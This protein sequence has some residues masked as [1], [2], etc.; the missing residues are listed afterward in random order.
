MNS[1]AVFLFVSVVISAVGAAFFVYG[2]KQGRVPQLIVGIAMMLYPYFITNIW[3]M[4]GIGAGLTGLVWAA[5][6]MGW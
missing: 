3:V 2:K 5:V 4:I 6:R 1:T